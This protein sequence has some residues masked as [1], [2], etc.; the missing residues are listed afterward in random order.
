MDGHVS[1]TTPEAAANKAS[2]N[3]LSAYASSAL[4][5]PLQLD[6]SGE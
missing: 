3:R 2:W 5:S 6:Q 1:A 4:R